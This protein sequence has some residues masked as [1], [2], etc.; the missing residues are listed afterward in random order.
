MAV[1]I[2]KNSLILCAAMNEE[3][4]GDTYIDDGLHYEL[5]VIRKILVTTDS[6]SLSNPYGQ[7]W[8][9]GSVPKNVKINEFYL[10]D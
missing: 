8:W 7:W 9:K 5:S 4:A 1:R 6:D 10:K 2:R 3:R